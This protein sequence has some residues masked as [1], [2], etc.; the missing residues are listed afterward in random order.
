MKNM[1]KENMNITVSP[2]TVPSEKTGAV[3]RRLTLIMRA[4]GFAAAGFFF[5]AAELPFQARIL[6]VSLVC[7][8]SRGAPFVLLGIVGRSVTEYIF[9]QDLDMLIFAFGSL[10]A[11]A[12]RVVFSTAFW[13]PRDF[14]GLVMRDGTAGR[15]LL[16]AFVTAV[17]SAAVLII[18]DYSFSLL[19]NG[20]FA[21]VC[22]AMFTFL[23]SLVFE[24]NYK[25]T[26]FYDT[27]IAA[28]LFAA[29]L[30]LSGIE[31]FGLSVQLCAAFLATLY[32]GYFGQA[33]RGCATGLFIGIA[34][35]GP[36]IPLFAVAGLA[37]GVFYR[38]GVLAGSL[39]S[40][41]IFVCGA[42]LAGTGLSYASYLPEI[43]VGA[44]L[45]TV[46]ALIGALPDLCLYGRDVP[47]AVTVSDIIVRRREEENRRRMEGLSQT[48]ASISD[49]LRGL[50]DKFRVPDRS[51][52]EKMC[53]DIWR[54]H[55]TEC[56]GGCSPLELCRGDG[57][58]LDKFTARLMKDGKLS[59]DEIGDLVGSDCGH[60]NAILGDVNACAAR[61][62]GEAISRDKTQVFA[63][64]YD[65]AAQMLADA[66][67]YADG[68]YRPDK[69]LTE[70]LRRAFLVAGIAAENLVV[71]GDRKKAVIACGGE[72]ARATLGTDDVRKLC[73]K[74]CGVAMTA[75]EFRM[76]GDRVAMTLESACRFRVE[77][78]GK[79]SV[80]TG[81][82]YC[83]DA[84]SVVQTGD[85]YFYSF[86]C[87]G[88]GSGRDAALTARICRVF[89][90]KMLGCGNKK[91]TTLEML[92][93]IVRCKNTECFAT[94]DLLEIDLMLGTASF[95]KSGATPSYVI[96]D[97]KLFKIASSTAPIGILP[98]IRAEVTEFDLR[99]NDIIV[100][101]SD[102]IAY[103]DELF[104]ADDTAWFA[105][106]LENE[107]GDDL[108]AM[109]E[110]IVSMASCRNSRSDDMTV[111]LIRVRKAERDVSPA[112]LPEPA[113]ESAA[114]E[115]DAEPAPEPVPES[116]A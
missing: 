76:E 11:C 13:R 68:Q 86:I 40:L 39:L 25:Y 54:S 62:I 56:G 58:F 61:M 98:Q 36:Y 111:E 16:S 46:P 74:V 99:E 88:M 26:T 87:D 81:E 116:V 113:G 91:S 20:I 28:F 105:E 49:I 29:T 3:L 57:T 114:P 59:A 102:G 90:E 72:L 107:C 31:L 77:H 92:N 115:T 67:V 83:G 69:V 64:D 44:V 50:S 66:V 43:A 78:A 37:A 65:A 103:D 63:Y 23:F 94:V 106:M 21:T 100:L 112:P 15:I 7:A 101:S 30:S 17:A 45:V 53:R 104:R 47:D 84:V 108:P 8:V 95:I 48:M 34:C 82:E 9:A 96:R 2:M 52:V 42:T 35:G 38:V 22:A 71:C 32:V 10:L 75:P 97:G 70:R 93:T 12:A 19:L 60:L 51:S 14:G 109:A 1:T 5:C 80:K 33:A 4:F 24:K 73:E 55:C 6:G 79:Q 27:G 110:K 85:G 18:G 89:L 41:G